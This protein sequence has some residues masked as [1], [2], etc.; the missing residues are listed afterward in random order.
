VAGK[1]KGH[2]KRVHFKPAIIQGVPQDYESFNKLVGLPQHPA[3]LQTM[4]M[5]PWQTEFF[6]IVNR[7]QPI[8]V[9][10]NKA[11]Q[12]GFTENMQRYF[13]YQ[14]FFKYAGRKIINIAGTREKTSKKI[15]QRLRSLFNNIENTIADNGT[16]L[17][18]KL[19]NGTEYEAMPSNSSASRGDTKIAAFGLDEA[20][21]FGLID[22][23][24]V[25]DAIIPIADTNHSDVFAYSTPNG[26]RGFFYDLTMQ[27]NDFLKLQ[28]N[29]Y[30]VQGYLHTEDEIRKM[31]TRTDIDVDQEYLCQF[32]ASHS[33][34]FTED[35]LEA[36]R[37]ENYRT[38]DLRKLLGYDREDGS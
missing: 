21:H 7:P 23:S 8:K 6:D 20:A 28:Y 3:T 10:I 4:G 38:T 31:L 13:A 9:H 17:W 34:V 16:D 22:D 2:V 18:F 19:K 30:K 24:V 37:D 14:G 36:A 25:I 33:A 5:M 26:R 29:I 11:R 12:I 1:Q 27:E 35:M 32:T 15:Q